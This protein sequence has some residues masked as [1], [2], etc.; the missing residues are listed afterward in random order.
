MFA[1]V[2]EWEAKGDSL[3]RAGQLDE[4][5]EAYRRA[6]RHCFQWTR[7]GDGVR[8]C[9]EI[10]EKLWTVQLDQF[11][12]LVP[13][14]GAVAPA[15]ADVVEWLAAMHWSQGK[16]TEAQRVIDNA[17][18]RGNRSSGEFL[19]R[20]AGRWLDKDPEGSLRFTDWACRLR[21]ESQSSAAAGG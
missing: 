16:R 1:E 14:A 20:L 5:V 12:A 18:A 19:D 8:A 17:I 9:S 6:L 21:G 7:G 13:T 2:M 11:E 10:R 4:A 3:R 15:G